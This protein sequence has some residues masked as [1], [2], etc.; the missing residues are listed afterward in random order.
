[1]RPVGFDEGGG[2]GVDDVV[3]HSN[4]ITSH[5]IVWCDVASG[6]VKR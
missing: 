2:D 3:N 1:M 6:T 5:L 4:Y